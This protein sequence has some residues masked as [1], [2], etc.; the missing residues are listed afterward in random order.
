MARIVKLSVS[1]QRVGCV[2]TEFL[3]SETGASMDTEQPGV[4][5]GPGPS[6]VSGSLFLSR[7]I[8]TQVDIE[9]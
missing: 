3:S 8:D 5:P 7:T 6:P 2:A 4:Q 1:E 9:L